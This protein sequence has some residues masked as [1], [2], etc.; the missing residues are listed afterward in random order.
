[1][2]NYISFNRNKRSYYLFLLSN[3]QGPP[4][5]TDW[6]RLLVLQELLKEYIDLQIFWRWSFLV[7]WLLFTV[8]R[9][10]IWTF[11]KLKKKKNDFGPAAKMAREKTKELKETHS[12]FWKEIAPIALLLNPWIHY[13]M[14]LS[15]TEINTSKNQIIKRMKK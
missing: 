5:D 8:Y 10:Y 15:K 1:M 12:I 11:K 6:D 13:E 4:K 9:C 7:I 3:W 2:Q 14:H